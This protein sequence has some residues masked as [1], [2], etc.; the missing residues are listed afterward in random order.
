MNILTREELS[1]LQNIQKEIKILQI[2]ISETDA[3]YVKD[4]VLGS[5]S[6]FPYTQR[7]FT[8]AGYDYDSYYTKLNRLNRRLSRKLNELMDERDKLNSYIDTISDPVMRMILTLKHIN[9]MTWHQISGKIGYTE[10]HCKRK[11]KE[12]FEKC[13]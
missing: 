5:D 8:L 10:R 1:K 7:S 13:P 2:Q 12:F 3:K 4:K 9:G 6:S 11:Y